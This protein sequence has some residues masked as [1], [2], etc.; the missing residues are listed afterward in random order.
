[1]LG[2]IDTRVLNCTSIAYY[3]Y[4]LS[5]NMKCLDTYKKVREDITSF[6]TARRSWV[7]APAA[8]AVNGII[9]AVK[10]DKRA[11]GGRGK[12]EDGKGKSLDNPSMDNTC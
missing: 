7:Q 8:D 9:H 10:G 6:A 3:D 1:M 12:G 5:L 11:K 2:V 4:I